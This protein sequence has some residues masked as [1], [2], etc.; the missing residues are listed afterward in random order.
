MIS[1]ISLVNVHYHVIITEICFC[2]DKNFFLMATPT[3]YGSF[4]ARDSI[5]ATAETYVAPEAL[6]DPLTY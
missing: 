4:Q 5:Q 1:T 2:C 6:P 3:T